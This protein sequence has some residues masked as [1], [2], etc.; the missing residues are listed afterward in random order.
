MSYQQAEILDARNNVI[1]V[2]HPTAPAYPQA[3]LAAAAA[4]AATTLTVDDNTGFSNGDYMILGSLGQPKTELTKVNGAVTAGS[5]L[6]VT[7]LTFDHAVNAPLAV[8]LWNQVEISGAA[9]ISGSKTVI[10]TVEL[11]VD[12]PQTEYVNAG[13]AYAYYFARYYNSTTT[14]FGS[15]SDAAPAT[16]YAAD[17]VRAVKKTALQNTGEAIGPLITDDFLNTEITNCEIDIWKEKRRWA[18]FE[19]D[20]VVIGTLNPGIVL[21][22]MPSDISDPDTAEAIRM[23]RVRQIGVL[24]Y[25]DFEGVEGL[26][27]DTAVSALAVAS[28]AGDTSITLESVADFTDYGSVTLGVDTLTYTG[29]DLN[30]NQLTG[31]P[32]SGQGS[33]TVSSAIGTN[34]WQ[35]G[36]VETSPTCWTAIPGYISIILPPAPSYWYQALYCSYYSK[37]TYPTS[38]AQTLNWP[39]PTLYHLYLAWK[40]CMRRSNGTPTPEEENF[41]NLYDA[42]KALLLSRARVQD[43]PRF[44]PKRQFGRQTLGRLPDDNIVTWIIR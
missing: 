6:T 10:A 35:G 18:Q 12:A 29:R 26:L 14:T 27:W 32:T 39:D 8:S 36:L 21:F 1:S 4:A 23:L 7:A 34:V 5:S 3:S 16:G 13:T 30:A 19:K 40:I 33:I 25:L 37:P 42:R 2:A 38:D 15:Y 28:N 17:T 11:K 41:K 22:A 43:T 31:I 44:T 24:Q 20:A 9:S